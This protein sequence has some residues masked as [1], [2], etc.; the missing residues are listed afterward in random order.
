[1]NSRSEGDAANAAATPSTTM[2]TTYQARDRRCLG[3]TRLSASMNDG[4]SST[5]PVGLAVIEGRPS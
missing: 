2:S 5:S 4:R 3:A 1:M